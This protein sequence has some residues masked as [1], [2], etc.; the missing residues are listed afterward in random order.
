MPAPCGAEADVPKKFGNA[1]PSKANGGEPRLTVVLPP[2]GV[3]R[4][5]LFLAT[6]SPCMRVPPT[7]EKDAL[8]GT[9]TPKAGVFLYN[10]APQV[11]APLE[12]AC[13]T[14][15]EFPV[16]NSLKISILS[17]EVFENA[18]VGTALNRTILKR[19]LVPV[20]DSLVTKILVEVGWVTVNESISNGSRPMLLVL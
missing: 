18:A 19:T 12:F 17:N 4:S 8:V 7:D 1:S 5:G 3:Q 10:T 2:F 16:L 20:P 6:D 15:V 9:F 11:I 13:P 14:M